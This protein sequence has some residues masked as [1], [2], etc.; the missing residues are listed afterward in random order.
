MHLLVV[1]KSKMGFVGGQKKNNKNTR[2]RLK[3]A[4]DVA[5]RTKKK[6]I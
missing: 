3:I 2:M 6:N 1:F 4:T 5:E